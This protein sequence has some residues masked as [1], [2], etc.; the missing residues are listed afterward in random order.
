MFFSMLY[1]VIRNTSDDFMKVIIGLGNPGSK[2]LFTRHNAGFMVV[3][4][5]ALSVEVVKEH[6]KWWGL[7]KKVLYKGSEVIIVKPLTYMNKSGIAAEEILRLA[8][9]EPENMLVVHDDLDL[10]VGRLRVVRK[11][12]SGGHKGV[13][14][15]IGAIGTNEFPRLKIGIGRPLRGESIY[16]Y[17]L[18][19]PY[20]DELDKFHKT[21]EKGVE[22]LGVILEHG[23][24]EAMNRFNG[25]ML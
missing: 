21:L 8:C 13:N 4:K 7:V 24:E 9:E 2:Y 19:P 17:V 6:T 3:D 11:G 1:F 15:I 12:G 23:I 16:N 14:S 22:A 5:F 20:E 10:P 18:S 25:L